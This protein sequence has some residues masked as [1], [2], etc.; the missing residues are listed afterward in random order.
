LARPFGQSEYPLDVLRRPPE[1]SG[2]AF[3]FTLLVPI[4]EFVSG[5]AVNYK[6]VFSPTDFKM[7]GDL[8]ENDFGGVTQSEDKTHPLL[9]GSW[10]SKG[11]VIINKHARYELYSQQNDIAIDYFKELKKNLERHTGQ[12][13]IVIEMTHVILM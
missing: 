12:E 2:K 4:N 1:F 13:I 9:R 11:I 6:Q 8:L 7:L 10:T 3:K 5:Q